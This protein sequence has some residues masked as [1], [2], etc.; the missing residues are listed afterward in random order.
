MPP[1][2]LSFTDAALQG[3][4][5]Y[6]RHVELAVSDRDLTCGPL[7]TA[8][9]DTLEPPPDPLRGDFS[10]G[11]APRGRLWKCVTHRPGCYSGRS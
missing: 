1:P 5:L 11:D 4:P 6:N 9:P 7:L 8:P 10:D 3:V 2:L